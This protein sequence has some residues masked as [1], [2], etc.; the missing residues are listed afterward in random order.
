MVSWL[1]FSLGSVTH[2]I[3]YKAT[4]FPTHQPANISVVLTEIHS[5]LSLAMHY[6]TDYDH[7]TPITKV[8]GNLQSQAHSKL[9]WVI[10]K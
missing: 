2:R 4:S 6:G 10:S 3:S 8:L 7:L 1:F 5:I 9:T